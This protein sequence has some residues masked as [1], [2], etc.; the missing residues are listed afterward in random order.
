MAVRYLPETGFIISWGVIVDGFD[1]TYSVM[2]NKSYFISYFVFNKFPFSLLR[3]LASS[4]DLC[5]H[6]VNLLSN[7]SIFCN[8]VMMLVRHAYFR[9]A[10]ITNGWH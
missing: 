7:F 1:T 2:R 9:H 4:L 8:Q 5:V 6:I 3:D 10:F